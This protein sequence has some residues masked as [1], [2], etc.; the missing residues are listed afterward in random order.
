MLST[1]EGPSNQQIQLMVG[2]QREERIALES[3]F[4]ADVRRM[5]SDIDDRKQHELDDL[6]RRHKAEACQRQV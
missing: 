3:E 2:Q 6:E 4:S 5:E 1:G